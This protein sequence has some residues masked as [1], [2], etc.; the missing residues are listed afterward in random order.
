MS[1]IFWFGFA[2]GMLTT[3]ILLLVYAF[4]PEGNIQGHRSRRTHQG[5]ESTQ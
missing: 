4:L 3:I 5:P 2:S 1:S